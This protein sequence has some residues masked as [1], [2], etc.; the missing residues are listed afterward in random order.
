M[1]SKNKKQLLSQTQYI[2]KLGIFSNLQIL[3]PLKRDYISDYNIEESLNFANVYIKPF[4]SLIIA[5]EFITNNITPVIMNIVSPEFTGT[6]IM[7]EVDEIYDENLVIRTN[8]LR[9]VNTKEESIYPLKNQEVILSPCVTVI[10]NET[11]QQFISNP[12]ELYRVGVITASVRE[13]KLINNILSFDDYILIRE[14]IENVF[15]T[16]HDTGYEAL[17]L[18]DFSLHKTKIPINDI[19]DIYNNLILKY[20]YLFK[21]IVIA[22][23]YKTKEE[24]EC[25]GIFAKEIIK[26][27]ELVDNNNN[28]FLD[29]M[30]NIT[31]VQ[32]DYQINQNYGQMVSQMNNYSK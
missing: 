20:G 29:K 21:Y 24:L 32:Q 1:D 18:T 16:A 12:K 17:I 13:M 30:T 2:C 15:Q 4:H 28:N 31:D 19:I 23:P 11:C 8:Y 25:F 6:N 7:N 10:K 14:I 27:Q 9:T 5:K 3:R 22:I 26:P